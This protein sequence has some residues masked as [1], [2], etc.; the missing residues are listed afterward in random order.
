MIN[1]NLSFEDIQAKLLDPFE[2][3][4]VKWRVQRSG[5]KSDQGSNEPKPWAIVIPYISVRAVQQRLDDVFGTFGWENVFKE[6]RTGYLCGITIHFKGK[7][8]TKWDGAEFTS[9]EALKGGISGSMKR[10]A[11]QLGIGRYLYTLKEEFAP[12]RA[13]YSQREVEQD[14]EH[15]GKTPKQKGNNV[16]FRQH[17][18]YVHFAWTPPRLPDIALPSADYNVY[19]S[20]LKDA[21][22]IDDSIEAFRNVY[23][24]AKIRNNLAQM[25]ESESNYKAKKLQFS[26]QL[27]KKQEDKAVKISSWLNRSIKDLIVG[28]ENE[29][30]LAS[31]FKAIKQELVGRC[32]EGGIIVSNE[33][34]LQHLRSEVKKKHEFFNKPQ[35]K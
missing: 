1:E 17:N 9:M 5:F 32:K 26:D 22:N 3:S 10:C 20:A 14:T 33:T 27:I 18:D 28:A 7:S 21:E 4:D 31:S 30:T 6:T 13:V 11:V 35:G 25:R 24:F 29:S 12:C 15:Y 23:K 8:V 16:K 2:E 34:Y 19:L